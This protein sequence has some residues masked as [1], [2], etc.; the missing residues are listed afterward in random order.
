MGFILGG[1]DLITR[2]KGREREKKSPLEY[3]VVIV[4][5]AHTYIRRYLHI[6]IHESYAPTHIYYN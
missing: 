6:H 3:A 4:E 5:T 2:K 1:E